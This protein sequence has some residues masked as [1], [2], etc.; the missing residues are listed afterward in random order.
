MFGHQKVYRY[1][2]G[3]GLVMVCHDIIFARLLIKGLK[4]LGRAEAL[5]IDG[6]VEH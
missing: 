4:V 5:N 2:K 1:E 6:D 3:M